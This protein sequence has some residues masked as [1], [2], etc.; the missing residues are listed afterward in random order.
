MT[1]LIKDIT[2]TL[3]T[4]S[5]YYKSHV[6]IDLEMEMSI[7]NNDVMAIDYAI[8]AL[9]ELQGHREAWEKCIKEI[10]EWY[11]NA[12]KQSIAKDPCVVDAMVDLF[13]RTIKECRPKEGDAE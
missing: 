6:G 8:K 5:T 13:I 7:D 2:D 4:I 10:K 9:E 12:D 3:S 1:M 11:W